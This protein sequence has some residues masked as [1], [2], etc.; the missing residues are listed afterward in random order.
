MKTEYYRKLPHFQPE[1]AVFSIV[2]R[3]KGSLPSQIIENLKEEKKLNLIS[4]SDYFKMFDSF[5]DKSNSANNYLENPAV[6]DIVKTSIHF[7][8]KKEYNLICYCI[9]PNHVH[10]IIEKCKKELYRILQS[11]KAYTAREANKALA[12]TGK[13]WQSESY[14]HVIK[15][16]NELE[17]AMVYILNNPANANLVL[18]WKDWKYSYCDD[19]LNPLM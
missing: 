9:M 10:L 18:D 8:D 5:L 16:D 19:H 1:G 17:N 11:I 15:D 2:F 14:D 12:R 3:L 4:D 7:L 13:F 6:A